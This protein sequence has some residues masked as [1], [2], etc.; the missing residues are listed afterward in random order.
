MRLSPNTQLFS[1][2]WMG[3]QMTTDHRFEIAPDELVETQRKRSKW[4]SCLVGCLI[5]FGIGLVLA[6]ALAVW[7]G[8]NLP[9]WA[10]D[11]GSQIVNQ[12]I[13][14]SDF[15]PQEKAELKEQVARV[16]E[17][18]RNR[19]ISAHQAGQIFQRI[20][21]S[22]LMPIIVVTAVEK[23]Y[24]DRSGLTDQE[25]AEGRVTLKRFAR[26]AFD[27]KIDKSGIDAV[28]THVANR[29]SDGQWEMRQQVSDAELRAALAEAKKQADDAEI[30]NEPEDIDPSAVLKEI[31]DEALNSKIE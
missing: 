27:Q 16:A 12:A 28:M 14:Q 10:A 6:I 2:S 17:G 31:V 1:I 24:L 21:E 3:S 7:I 20:V 30:A 15:P 22:P 25:K 19:N 11:L 18:V 4:T 8:R 9:G 26:G 5:V 13:D 23:Q 29:K